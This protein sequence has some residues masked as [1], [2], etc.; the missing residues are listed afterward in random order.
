MSVL[1]RDDSS[2]SLALESEE[3]ESSDE[4]CESLSSSWESAFALR[5]RLISLEEE[6][7]G[8]D[9]ELVVLQK[10]GHNRHD[11]G[12]TPESNQGCD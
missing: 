6:R 8:I 4:I 2:L 10:F 12:Q 9:T 1:L 11:E 5:F 7:V 3:M